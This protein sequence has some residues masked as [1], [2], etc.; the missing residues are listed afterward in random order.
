MKKITTFVFRNSLGDATN[1][2]LTSREDVITLHYGEINPDEVGDDDLVLIER[3]LWGEQHN[4][5]MPGDIFKSG[6]CPMFGGNFVYTSDDRFPSD[7]PI[8]VFDR[9]EN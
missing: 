8:K 9:L 4:Y 3:V 6:R 2:G 5:C 7:A 1:W